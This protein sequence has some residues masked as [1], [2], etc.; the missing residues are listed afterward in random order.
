MLLCWDG[1]GCWLL[2]SLLLFGL[3]VLVS[4]ALV[5]VDGMGLVFTCCLFACLSLVVNNVV[6]ICLCGFGV[7]VVV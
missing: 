5:V 6:A 7:F 3:C 2:T 1:F 4:L